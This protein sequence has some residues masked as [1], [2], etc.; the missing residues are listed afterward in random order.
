[1][2]G[3]NQV[4]TSEVLWI[5]DIKGDTVTFTEPLRFDHKKDEI[6]SVEYVRY[7]MWGSTPM[8]AP[9]SGTTM[10]SAPRPGRTAGSA[11]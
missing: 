11:R 1:M 7:R 4:K 5:K 6:A 2:I 8:S 3:M 9:F 10:P